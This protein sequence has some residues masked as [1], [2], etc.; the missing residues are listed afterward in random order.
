MVEEVARGQTEE[1]EVEAKRQ[2]FVSLK[3]KILLFRNTNIR[4]DRVK[5]P[6]SRTSSF[7][8]LIRF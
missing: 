2:N 5:I 6:G 3:V 1:E 7:K 4:Q 8:D